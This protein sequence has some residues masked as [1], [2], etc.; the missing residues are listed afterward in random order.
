M[1]AFDT[2][3]LSDWIRR[4]HN[5]LLHLRDL[6]R[7][8]LELVRDGGMSE[9]LD[10]LAA[11]QQLLVELQRVE[12]GLD[13]FRGQDPDARPWRSPEDRRRCAEQLARCEALLAEIVSQEKES[14]RDLLRRRDEAAQRLQGVHTAAQARSAYAGAVQSAS[15]GLDMTS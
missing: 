4:K 15:S 14:E 9:L 11:K 5:C 7:R 8:Q 2:D 12:R 6:G 3:L 1:S 13:P 10:V